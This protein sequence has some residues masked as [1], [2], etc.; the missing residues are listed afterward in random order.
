MLTRQFFP[1]LCLAVGLML[2]TAKETRVLILLFVAIFSFVPTFALSV[3]ALLQ[4]L[5]FFVR[6]L[7]GYLTLLLLLQSGHYATTS[8]IIFRTDH[9]FL[10]EFVS[11]A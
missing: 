1:L 6:G 2:L 4:F 8:V 7:Q 3:S 11:D 10:L 9:R 5:L